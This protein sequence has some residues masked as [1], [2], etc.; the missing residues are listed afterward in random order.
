MDQCPEIAFT[1]YEN[2]ENEHN[3]TLDKKVQ[4]WQIPLQF[5]ECHVCTSHLR[6]IR[7]I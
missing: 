3:E 4:K 6:L 5:S 7:L 1:G 2:A